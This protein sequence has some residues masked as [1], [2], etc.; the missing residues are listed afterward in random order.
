MGKVILIHANC[1]NS[2]AKG[3]FSFAGNIAKDIIRELK[4]Q[5]IHDID[6]VL[7]SSLDGLPKFVSMYGAVINGRLDI[8][9]FNIGLSSLEEFDSVEHTVMAFIDANR[10]KHSPADIIKRALSPESKFLFVGNVIFYL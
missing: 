6:V 5:S 7:V 8:E 3:D 1:H 4:S 2:K 10:C 9:G